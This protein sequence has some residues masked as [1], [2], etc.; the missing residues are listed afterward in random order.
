[1]FKVIN[2]N[3]EILYSVRNEELSTRR[4]KRDETLPEEDGHGEELVMQCREERGAAVSLSTMAHFWKYAI[5]I[6]INL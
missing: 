5:I 1:M 6:K 3:K 2:Q 4:R